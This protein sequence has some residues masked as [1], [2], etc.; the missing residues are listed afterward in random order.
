VKGIAMSEKKSLVLFLVL[1]G[2]ILLHPA[3]K[4]Q[5][6]IDLEVLQFPE[7]ETVRIEMVSSRHIA[8]S[9]AFAR[10]SF[11]EG[12][13]RIQFQYKKLKPAVLFS[14]DVTCYVMWAVGRDGA[15]ENLGEVWAR[16][17]KASDTVNLSTGL[18]NFALLV[19]AESYYLVPQPSPLVMFQS[20]QREKNPL[21][22]TT[23]A[24]SNFGTPPEIGMDTLANV[25]YDGKTPLD[26]LQAQKVHEIA[27]RMGAEKHATDA[28][29]EATTALQQATIMSSRKAKKGAQEYARRAVAAS[30]DS[31]RITMRTEEALALEERIAARQAEMEDMEAR[32]KEASGDR[33]EAA[34]QLASSQ[35]ELEKLSAERQKLSAESAE[36]EKTVQSL[37]QREDTL[38]ASLSGLQRDLD[39][40]QKEKGQ[41][42]SSLESALGQ[43]ADT[44][45]SAEGFIVNLPD[46]LFDVNKATLK[47]EAQIVIAKMAGILL[48]LPDLTLRV[49]GHTDSTGSEEHN[50]TLSKR[51]AESVF[52]FLA[53]SGIDQ[54]RMTATGFGIQRPVADNSTAEGRKKN[55]RVEIIILE[56]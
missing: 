14:G 7:R 36:L 10:I 11:R 3:I 42:K 22:S 15:A 5:E 28:F 37:G 18:R 56:G 16:P 43:I 2:F 48:V 45:K 39:Q 23:L 13:S 34:K 41:L 17:E 40:V 1:V 19:T 32:L 30:N 4:A 25:R 12:Q 31:I 55:R 49:E 24:F 33:D 51:R 21:Q 53:G 8:P 44:K 50:L 38:K 54:S 20:Q 27:S 6:G 35:T 9:E 29:R 47:A 46:I 26:L 52:S